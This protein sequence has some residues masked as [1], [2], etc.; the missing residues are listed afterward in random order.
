MRFRQFDF[1]RGPERFGC[2]LR[3][4]KRFFGGIAIEVSGQ[5]R[6]PQPATRNYMDIRSIT[7]P[8]PGPFTL[9]G[10]RT[11]STVNAAR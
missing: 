8:N 9:D 7:A 11:S 4:R 10:T 6:N 3:Y 5:P 2:L 1:P